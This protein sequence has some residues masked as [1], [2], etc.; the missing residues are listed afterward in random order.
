M[1][2]KSGEVAEVR[3][4]VED[5]DVEEDE[6]V[7]EEGRGERRECSFRLMVLTG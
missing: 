3:E 7:D 2:W 5:V 6:E 1:A 4:D